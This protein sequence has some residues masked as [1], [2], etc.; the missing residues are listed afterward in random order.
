MSREDYKNSLIYV[1]RILEEHI[2]TMRSTYGSSPVAATDKYVE[3]LDAKQKMADLLEE[4]Y[5]KVYDSETVKG[6]I[7]LQSAEEQ[8]AYNAKIAEDIKNR[9]KH[10]E[11]AQ[12]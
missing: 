10:E 9:R 7:V 1:T 12:S 5:V 2:A 8:T 3:L 6:K 11:E 4:E